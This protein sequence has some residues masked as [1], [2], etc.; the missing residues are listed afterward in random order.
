MTD[1][2]ITVT[3]VLQAELRHLE[4]AIKEGFTDTRGDIGKID[5]RL[6]ELNGTVRDHD[7]QL[8]IC[9]GVIETANKRLT[10]LE[11]WRENLLATAFKWM[12]IGGGAV[13]T[14]VLIFYG[15]GQAAGWW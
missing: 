4:T 1:D 8:T 5:A 12:M 11:Q 10:G 9:N 6:K 14:L 3:A 7:R 13:L 2:Q 15:L